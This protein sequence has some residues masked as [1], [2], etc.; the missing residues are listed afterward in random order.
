MVQTNKFIKL[1]TRLIHTICA[2]FMSDGKHYNLTVTQHNPSFKK[3]ADFLKM[4]N[5]KI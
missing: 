3:N 1:G 2:G 5:N 4:T